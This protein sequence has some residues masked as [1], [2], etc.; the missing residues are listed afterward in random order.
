MIVFSYNVN[1]YSSI[2]IEQFESLYGRR[3]RSPVGLF[4]IGE[5]ALHDLDVVYK[6]TGKVPRIRYRLKIAYSQKN[7]YTDNRRRDLELE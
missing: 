7:S 1:H 4:E 3:C 5:C 2:S 6:A